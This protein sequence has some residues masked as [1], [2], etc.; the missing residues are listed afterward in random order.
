MKFKHDVKYDVDGVLKIIL[1]AERVY[2]QHG[3]E[4]VVTSLMDGEHMPNSLHY[5][6]RAVDLRTFFFDSSEEVD[7]V[8]RE[9]QEALGEDYDIVVEPTHIHAEYDPK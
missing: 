6:G 1:F 2:E 5:Q 7:A 4:A 3:K 8:A 9:L